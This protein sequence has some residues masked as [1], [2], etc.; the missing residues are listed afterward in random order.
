MIGSRRP[1]RTRVECWAGGVAVLG[2][3]A[4]VTSCAV[5]SSV[6]DQ[7]Q[8]A[9]LDSLR[10]SGN[11][12]V[13]LYAAPIPELELFAIHPWFVV[14]QAD[15]TSYDRW[16]VWQTSGGAYGHVRKNRSSPT[17]SVGAG[18]TYV[19]AELV[20]AEAEAVVSFIESE[21]PDYPCKDNYVLFPGPNS[22]S[23]AQWVLDST[24]WD[25]VLPPTAIGK[26]VPAN[27]P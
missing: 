3:A 20:G 5:F 9:S 15:E 1:W 22:N 18:G 26:D 12:V 7:D 4:A 19:I 21:S 27:C 14:K 8:F 10:D 23:Y 2:I 17:T 24:G 16:E 6:P 25:V 13:R 11:A